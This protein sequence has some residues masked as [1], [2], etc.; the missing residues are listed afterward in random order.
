VGAEL[1]VTTPGDEYVHELSGGARAVWADLEIPRTLAELVHDL[2]VAHGA[3]PAEIAGDVEGCL[4]TLVA[5][6]AVEEA[7]DLDG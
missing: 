4:L 3:Q 6:G 1:L 5:C 2:A 7:G